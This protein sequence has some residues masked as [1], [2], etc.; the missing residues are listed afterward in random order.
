MLPKEQIEVES[1]PENDRS[2]TYDDHHN[3]YTVIGM[4]KEF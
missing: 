4:D 2:L 3:Y 1:A